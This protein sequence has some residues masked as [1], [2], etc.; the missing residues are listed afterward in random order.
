[1]SPPDDIERGLPGGSQDSSD[2]RQGQLKVPQIPAANDPDRHPPHDGLYEHILRVRGT[3]SIPAFHA[4]YP[5]TRKYRAFGYL[6]E[7]LLHRFQRQLTC[8]LGELHKLSLEEVCDIENQTGNRSNTKPA[9]SAFFDEEKFIWRC[10]HSSDQASLIEVPSDGNN[11]N[12]TEERKRTR[13]DAM[14]ENLSSNAERIFSLYR[15]QLHWVYELR[16]FPRPSY[17]THEDHFRQIQGLGGLGPADVDYLRA[18]DDFIYADADPL[19][20]RFHS[21]LIFLRDVLEVDNPFSFPYCYLYRVRPLG[22]PLT[23]NNA[24]T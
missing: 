13:R 14:T 2:Y 7:I 10:L 6:N 22:N 12:D 18:S 23:F 9:G 5:N 20:E 3:P 11:A 16:K 21:L 19:Y 24:N 4:R 1:M 17:K 15:A 8:I